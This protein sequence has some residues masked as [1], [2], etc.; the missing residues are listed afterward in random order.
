MAYCR[1]FVTEREEISRWISDDPLL[2]WTAIGRRLGRHRSTIQRE[3]VRNGGRASY[4]AHAA[5][6]AADKKR[7][8]RIWR[9]LTDPDLA[10]QVRCHLN[11]GYSPAGTA[12]LLGT[13]SAET[14]YTG[15]Y[16]GRLGVTASE[17]LRTRRCTRRPRNRRREHRD[18][19][20]LGVFTTIHD[21]PAR[22]D[23]RSEFGHWE[24]DLIIGA[25]NKSALITL[26]ERVSRTE[27]VLA[28]PHGYSADR[29][30]EQ[31][32]RWVSTKPLQELRS[33][34]WDRG[35]EMANWALIASGW[36]VDFYFADPHSPWQR[37]ANENANRQ[38]RFWLPKSTDLTVHAQTRLDQICEILNS[39]PRRALAWK[40][41]NHVYAAH[42]AH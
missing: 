33:I 18:T 5:Q 10:A 28:L 21:R 42:T 25:G 11:I 35:S 20:V 19:R 15:I 14:I 36:G 41:A 22:V 40:T 32:D 17:V 29:V 30:F 2:S 8:K 12:R 3:V 31:L 24:G 16:T 39:Q 1:L 38:L 23:D 9:F 13:V 6:H 34:T 26:V 27:V 7:P 37:G 4:R